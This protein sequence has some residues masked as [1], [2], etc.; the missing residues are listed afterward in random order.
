MAYRQTL[1]D[2]PLPNQVFW[3]IISSL[4]ARF[5]NMIIIF[6]QT[7]AITHIIK[8]GLKV[9]IHSKLQL[10]IFIREKAPGHSNLRESPGRI[11]VSPTLYVTGSRLLLE[12][13]W[14][15]CFL[16]N[17]QRVH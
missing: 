11:L 5:T 12:D 9:I 16:I 2:T 8:C 7:L 3:L 13:S 17:L 14:Y 15:H 10:L 6:Q 1:G 4:S